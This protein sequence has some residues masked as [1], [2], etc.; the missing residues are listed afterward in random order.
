MTLEE[1]IRAIAG[2]D[3]SGVGGENPPGPVRRAREPLP[4]APPRYPGQGV[5]PG[6]LRR[7][8]IPS[9]ATDLQGPAQ[10]RV[11]ILRNQEGGFRRPVGPGGVTGEESP[12]RVPFSS[13]QGARPSMGTA[14][15]WIEGGPPRTPPR[16]A[17]FRD[18]PVDQEPW[19]QP[20]NYDPLSPGT[21]PIPM[22]APA[23]QGGFEPPNAPVPSVTRWGSLQE[24][25]EAQGGDRDTELDVAFSA[26]LERVRAREAAMRALI[27]QT[28]SPASRMSG[29]S[30]LP[31]SARDELA[32]L[33]ARAGEYEWRAQDAESRLG[34]L[35]RRRPGRD[36]RR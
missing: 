19:R 15:D 21:T 27:D 2:G 4:Q 28:Q 36:Y 8:P 18:L 22:G 24:G 11:A 7:D 10:E 3:T 13:L 16:G 25:M 35:S 29:Q 26:A 12:L 34:R 32:E 17:L 23:R 33:R 6:A 20:E 1:L 31:Q 5:T 14:A 9:W 30:D